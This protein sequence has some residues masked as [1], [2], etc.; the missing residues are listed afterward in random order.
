MNEWAGD[1]FAS[2]DQCFEACFDKGL[3]HTT[4]LQCT[5]FNATTNTGC[6]ECAIDLAID[7]DFK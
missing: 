1:D 3:R 7:L 5:D 6:G 2:P 4:I